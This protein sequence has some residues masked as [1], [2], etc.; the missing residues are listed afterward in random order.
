MW[1]RPPHPPH[2]AQPPRFLTVCVCLCWD[3]E[4]CECLILWVGHNPSAISFLCAN[5]GREMSV[6]MTALIGAPAAH[7][8]HH[9]PLIHTFLLFWACSISAINYSN[10]QSLKYSQLTHQENRDE[11]TSATQTDFKGSDCKSSTSQETLNANGVDG[12]IFAQS[13]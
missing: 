3:Q 4:A 1:K 6:S 11:A 9:Y 2:A 7:R 13:A 12:N 8:P 10:R 5:H